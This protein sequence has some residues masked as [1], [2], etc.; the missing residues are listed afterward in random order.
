MQFILNNLFKKEIT[1]K[2]GNL[3]MP[4]MPSATVFSSG[5]LFIPKESI[6]IIIKELSF[7]YAN[8]N[9]EFLLNLS[10]PAIFSYHREWGRG[11]YH[12]DGGGVP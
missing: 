6:I 2:R 11:V 1:L 8:L 7:R 10:G 12:R 4:K 3:S 9:D 5:H